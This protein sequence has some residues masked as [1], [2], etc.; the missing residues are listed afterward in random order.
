[1]HLAEE[2]FGAS[3][4]EA[5]LCGSVLHVA[6]MGILLF[7]KNGT[8]PAHS[9]KLVNPENSK[10]VRFC[11]G[12]LMHGIPIGLIVYAGRNQFNHWDDESF[13]YPTT[14]VFSALLHAYCENTL[15]DMAYELQYPART[16][17]ANHL[18]LNELKWRT[19]GQYIA[20]MRA[21]ICA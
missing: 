4:S 7:S 11:V 6:F 8:V 18:M 10:A 16:I 20:D 14:Q 19:Y 9:S 2:Y 13:D 15:F 3:L 21:L 17:K 5:T 12:R 1:M